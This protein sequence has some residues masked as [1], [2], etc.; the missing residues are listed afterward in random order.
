MTVAGG[1]RTE[2]YRLQKEAP[3]TYVYILRNINLTFDIM[4]TYY[5]YYMQA[6]NMFMLHFV[7]H[8]GDYFKYSLIS[9]KRR[10]RQ[11]VT[12]TDRQPLRRNE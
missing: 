7:T 1:G 11:K 8:G 6:R 3:Y 12:Q 5:I 10:A 2:T 9:I 4:A